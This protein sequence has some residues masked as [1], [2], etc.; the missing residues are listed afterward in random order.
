VVE[1]IIVFSPWKSFS[2]PLFFCDGDWSIIRKKSSRGPLVY[3]VYL[4]L[5]TIGRTSPFRDFLFLRP[6]GELKVFSKKSSFSP[7]PSL[8]PF[9]GIFLIGMSNLVFQD[10]PQGKLSRFPE[11]FFFLYPPVFFRLLFFPPPPALISARWP[12]CLSGQKCVLLF[13]VSV[14]GDPFSPPQR[15]SGAPHL[16]PILVIAGVCPIV[17]PFSRN[18]F[19]GL[20]CAFCPHFELLFLRRWLFSGVS[21]S[22]FAAV[23][24]TRPP[25]DPALPI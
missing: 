18:L 14:G 25:L 23:L 12:S 2:P 21:F 24:P 17:P 4:L 1:Q 22:P 20:R 15:P 7:P 16:C 3:A 13:P 19:P 10:F 9:F 8:P 6:H 11:A 5:F